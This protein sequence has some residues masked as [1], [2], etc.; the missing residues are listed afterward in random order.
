MKAFHINPETGQEI[1]A[2]KVCG[3]S[4]AGFISWKRL[5]K[6]LC[7]CGEIRD[8]E[9]LLSFQVDERGICFRVSIPSSASRIQKK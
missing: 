8:Y 2:H 4:A 5:G 3:V 6:L 7:D 9:E 1:P